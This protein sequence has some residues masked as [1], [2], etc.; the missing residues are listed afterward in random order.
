MSYRPPGT[1]LVEGRL[2]CA[3]D[4]C[5]GIVPAPP[6]CSCNWCK[7]ILPRPYD[8]RVAFG[9]ASHSESKLERE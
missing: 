1:R 6:P 5:T 9:S 7:G 4:I 3:C 2:C 8:D